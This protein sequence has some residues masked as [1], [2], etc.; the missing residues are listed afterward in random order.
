MDYRAVVRVRW[1][2]MS[3]LAGCIGVLSFHPT[4]LAQIVPDRTLPIPSSV[5]VGDQIVNINGGTRTGDNLF[6]SFEQ[7]S[8]P[9]G[10]EAHFN[11][12]GTV[13][14]IVARVTGQ[15]PSHLDGLLAANGTANLFLLNPNGILFG[16]N[17][18]LEIGGSFFATTAE[19]LLFQDGAIFETNANAAPPILSVSVPLGLQWSG[20]PSGSIEVRGRAFAFTTPSDSPLR[21]PDVREGLQV[22]AGQT[23]ALLGGSIELDRASLDAPNGQIE[24]AGI[25]SGRIDF[26]LEVG[27]A[28]TYNIEQFGDLAF[29]RAVVTAAGDRGGSI[30]LRGRQ[31]DIANGTI[32]AVQNLGTLSSGSIDL[33]ASRGISLFGVTPNGQ[34]RT[35]VG[36]QALGSGRGG[37]IFIETPRLLLQDGGTVAAKSF[38]LGRGGDI[39]I[40]TETSV[41]IRGFSSTNPDFP[42]IIGA[43]AYDAGD[44]GNVTVRSRHLDVTDGALLAS[45]TFSTGN[46][47]ILN[48]IG[49]EQIN[50]VG[51][52]SEMFLPSAII[53]GSLGEG[54]AESLHIETG[55]LSVRGGGQVSASTLALGSAGQLHIHA[56]ES[57]EVVGQFQDVIVSTIDSSARILDPVL[58]DFLGVPPRP[59]G[60]TGNVS[61]ETPNLSVRDGA[62]VS[63]NNVGVGDGGSLQIRAGEVELVGGNL[64]AS[65]RLGEGGS[66]RL[67]LSDRLTMRDSSRIAATA[68]ASGNGGNVSIDAP[69]IVAFNNSDII[70]N[71]VSGSG[72]NVNIATTGVFGARFRPESTA[73]SDITASS[74]FGFSGIVNI[75]ALHLELPSGL[76]GIS[77]NLTDPA[78]QIAPACVADEN[79]FIV[80]GRGG[81]PEDPTQPLRSPAIWEDRRLGE[82]PNPRSRIEPSPIPNTVPTLPSPERFVEANAWRRNA[83]GQ[84]ELVVESQRTLPTPSCYVTFSSL[85]QHPSD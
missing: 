12:E 65:T 39:F 56:S 11:N 45:S 4:G 41:A 17:A 44:A 3:Y 71:A 52:N 13:A 29:D 9:T 64:T 21:L 76:L 31:I 28:F 80:T 79:T 37:D 84:V 10:F 55:R 25:V 77:I 43:V 2:W 72:G 32:V 74:E 42:S 66:V 22:S 75:T 7:F 85:R 27:S 69:L 46:G 59:S 8:V 38:G 68:S 82:I 33:Y 58:Q 47:G 19:R 73:D 15:M 6:H 63:V 5:R 23:L 62:S 50:V 83:L 81:L 16:E 36:S 70:A 30:G 24:I 67:E 53:I 61:I 20:N 48:A 18:H 14:N 1:A 51:A 34:I 57:I 35:T 49:L 26:P 54:N 78:R 40:E 60:Q